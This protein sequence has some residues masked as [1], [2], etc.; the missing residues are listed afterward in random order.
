MLLE[1]GQ[2]STTCSDITE[3]IRAV[4]RTLGRIMYAAN[5]YVALSDRDEGTVRFVYF[6]DE[7]D[8]GPP[9]NQPVPLVPPE[10]SPTAWVCRT[11]SPWW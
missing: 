5:F 1:I 9:L 2:T 8:E 10:E 7:S 6:V 4:H 3:F 11:A